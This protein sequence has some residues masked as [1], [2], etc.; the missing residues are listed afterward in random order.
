MTCVEDQD[1]APSPRL[2]R[3]GG[4][5]MWQ[6]ARDRFPARPVADA[7]PAASRPR[8]E[9][10]GELTG[11]PFILG[12]AGSQRARRRGIGLLLDWLEDQPGTTWQERWVAS[13]ADGLGP[14]WRSVPGGWLRDHG[15]DA[16][17]RLTG[18]SAA[19]G[20]A[21]AADLVRP[22]LRWFVAGGAARGV[23][24]PVFSAARDPAGFALLR[25][26]SDDDPGVSAVAGKLALYR[27]AVIAAA[28]GGGVGQITVGDVAELLA[29][30]A[31]VL[32]RQAVKAEV[33]YRL[34]R[35]AGIISDA[36]PPSLRQLRALGQRTPAELV[37]RY[38]ISCRP[39]RDLLV[40]YLRERQPALDYSS[41]LQLTQILGKLFWADLEHHHPGIA[42]L[43]LPPDVARAWKQR[44]QVKTRRA[45]TGDGSHAEVTA[46]RINYRE[47]MS[48]VRAFYLDIAEWAIE[49]PGRWAQWAAPCPVRENELQRRKAVRHRKS[50]MDDRTRQ[51]LPALPLLV[52]AVTQRKDDAA[53]LLAAARQAE[54]GQAFTAAGQTLTRA[55]VPYSA[56]GKT[57]AREPGGGRRR[58]LGQ[59]D[60]YAFWSWAVIQVLRL[61]GIRIEELLELSHYSLVQYRLPGTG[62]LVPLLQIAPS[63][64][65]AERLLLVSPELADVL[66]AIISRVRGPSG[67]VPLVAGYDRHECRYLPPAPLLFQRRHGQQNQPVGE[68]TIRRMLTATMPAPPSPARLTARRCDTLRTTSAVSSSPTRSS[69]G[70]RRTSLR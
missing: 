55:V 9:V 1:T 34:L 5:A 50:R 28:K 63:K 29:L 30:E 17:W 18:L 62:E 35:A 16:P 24:V 26:L 8:R 19:L 7:W 2:G 45:V 21:I 70:Y 60:D 59:E 49:D 25:Q 32:R 54:P 64:T 3:R 13:G 38:Q 23:L 37:D 6:P 68:W 52:T 61:T 67:A 46:P 66:A 48:H 14:G 53:A 27:A 12:L 69:T 31:A 15:Y 41:L 33:F 4:Q 65:D 44:L 56:A 57:W 40:D 20:V 22:S 39:V 51:R 47:C 10:I 58:D 36:A 42:S 43:R 11:P